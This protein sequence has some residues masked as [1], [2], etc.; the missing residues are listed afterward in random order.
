MKRYTVAGR[1]V[2]LDT[3]DEGISRR[4]IKT[5]GC[6]EPG[7]QWI[8]KREAHGVAYDVGANL[9][10]YT[11]LLA[12]RCSHVY[13]FEPDPRSHSLLLRNR[14][15]NTTVSYCAVCDE[16]LDDVRM[17]LDKRPNLTRIGGGD[18][19]AKAI[20][21]D[22]YCAHNRMPDFI[23]MD[24]E[25]GEVGAL[26]G[27]RCFLGDCRSLGLLIEVHPQYY[28]PQND[29]AAELRK[30]VEG[31]YRFKYLVNAK[32]KMCEFANYGYKPRKTFSQYVKRAVFEDIPAKLAIPWCCEMPDDGVKV[33]RSCYLCKG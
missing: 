3:K 26:R 15:V 12:E 11:I 5:N 32:G 20:T 9:G 14:R 7:F 1:K 22:Q 23:K 17:M 4:L 25:G 30:L 6:R 33:V 24:I 8:L 16:G 28:G 27:G 21:I 19:V 29:F 10:W 13:A 2:W 31:G 18:Y